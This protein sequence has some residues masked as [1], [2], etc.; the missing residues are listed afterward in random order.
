MLKGGKA[1]AVLD[2][3]RF[4]VLSLSPALWLDASQIN[5]LADGDPISTWLDLS[6][7]RR[8]ATSAGAARPTFKTN[9]VNGKPV[10]RFDGVGTF[11]TPGNV[12]NFE[13]TDLFSIFVVFQTAQ[14]DRALISKL[15]AGSTL[16]GW[17]FSVTSS[18]GENLLT[19]LSNDVGS[20]LY[21]QVRASVDV[22]NA[23]FW[24]GTL[25]YAGTS[26][27]SGVGFYTN[28]TLNT[29]TDV[30]DALGTNTMVHAGQVDI[31]ARSGGI[32]DFFSGDIA[33]IIVVS[34]V[35]TA[36]ELNLVNRYLGKK[37]GIVA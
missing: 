7:F 25:T 26:V 35:L 21:I 23:S 19:T 11:M 24:I 18:G 36:G 9:I 12:L 17:G 15:A 8:D 37:Y 22:I 10:A 3:P 4:N 20:N 33:E 34:R 16:R 32:A 31:G 13:R 30:K 5:G 14:A 27:A 1:R 29:N 6:G 2:P 28:G